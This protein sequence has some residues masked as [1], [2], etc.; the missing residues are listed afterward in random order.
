WMKKFV[1]NLIVST[2]MSLAIMASVIL[3]K[4]LLP[5]LLPT[6]FGAIGN[7]SRGVLDPISRL[8]TNVFSNLRSLHEMATRLWRLPTNIVGHTLGVAGSGEIA[9]ANINGIYTYEDNMF[10]NPA[11]TF[12]DAVLYQPGTS[13]IEADTTLGNI[14][15]NIHVYQVEA[16]HVMQ[17][18]LLGPLYLPLHIVSG[19]ISIVIGAVTFLP[20]HKWWHEYNFMEHLTHNP[21]APYGGGADIEMP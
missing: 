13:P 21:N 1:R 18:R 11:T 17:G 10:D 5:G 16:V 9:R 4:G 14:G 7:L 12:G 15:R 8:A 3:A 2:I 20:P 6:V 19:T